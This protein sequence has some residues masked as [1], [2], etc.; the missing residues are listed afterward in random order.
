MKKRLVTGIK[1]TGELTLGNYLGV[2]KPLIL[3]QN[4]F[5]LEYDFYLFIADLHAL[6][7]FQKPNL[8]KERI[9]K[10]ALLYL[11]VGFDISKINLFIQSEVPQHTYLS[12]I[13]E[14]TSYMGEL[15]RMNQFK[16]KYQ[17]QNSFQ[18][19]RTSYFT[20]PVLMAADIL[21]YDANIVPVGQD[22]K[23]HLELT[24]LLANR[25]NNLYG[26]TF[27]IPEFMP[28]GHTIKSLSNPLKKMSKSKTKNNID[29]KGCIFLL[30]D[31]E[32]TRDKIMKAVTDL[33]NKIN[34]DVE[35][36]PGIS[37]LLV[38][39]AALKNWTLDNTVNYFQN[40]SYKKFKE[41]VANLVSETLF[42]IQEQFRICQKNNYVYRILEDGACK[43]REITERKISQIKQKLGINIF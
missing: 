38:I 6:T 43:S 3:F 22:Q 29:D 2:I 7:I 35:K 18:S 27:V 17:M 39:Y 28:I 11:S 9:L 13:L 37:N 1:P 25:F 42:S 5:H 8:L 41:E 20:Y 23:Q 16:E 34:Y 33:E 21:I 24:R 36:Q 32:K 19:I 15:K 40:F 14:S 10:T 4:K 31:L 12:Y 30:E 26:E